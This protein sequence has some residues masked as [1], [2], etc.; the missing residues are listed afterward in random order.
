M[1]TRRHP[2]ENSH[3]IVQVTEAKDIM[4]Q[5]IPEASGKKGGENRSRHRLNRTP[6]LRC[7]GPRTR[8]DQEVA[9]QTHD[10]NMKKTTQ[11]TGETGSATRV[12]KG[13]AAACEVQ[14]G[15]GCRQTWNRTHIL[16]VRA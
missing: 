12:G 13:K 10:H 16:R 3:H 5:S 15:N 8:T 2:E 6:P 9:L 4:P 1:T 14:E 11:M 7:E